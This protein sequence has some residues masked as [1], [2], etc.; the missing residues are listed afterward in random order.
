MWKIEVSEAAERDLGLLFL[1]LANSYVE[2]ASNRREAAA[3]ARKHVQKVFA[4]RERIASASMRGERHDAWM[5]GLRHLIL[6]KG[7]YC[8]LVDEG[9]HG[10]RILAI[11]FGGQDHQRCMLLRL[12]GSP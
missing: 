10:I 11:F 9:A 7:V 6:D 4:A 12:L 5:P 3:Q 1:H 8:Y 2:F